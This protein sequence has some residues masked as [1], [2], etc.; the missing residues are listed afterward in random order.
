MRYHPRMSRRSPSVE[1]RP[2]IRVVRDAEIL[3]GPGKADLLEAIG[4]CG[5]IR[6]AAGELGMSYMRAWTLVKAMNDGFVE[7]LV[8]SSRGG[9]AHGGAGLTPMGRKV[10]DIYREMQRETL[11]ATASLRAKLEKLVR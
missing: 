9:A 8:E 11:E 2:R 5:S 4:H 10:L 3:L 1:I 6:R 7:P